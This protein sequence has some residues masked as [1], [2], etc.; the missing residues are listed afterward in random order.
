MLPLLKLV[1]DGQQHNL[2]EAVEQLAPEFQLSDED[3]GSEQEVSDARRDRRES[4]GCSA[5]AQPARV[6]VRTAAFF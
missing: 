6:A 1:S 3:Q 4:V 5:K 2:K